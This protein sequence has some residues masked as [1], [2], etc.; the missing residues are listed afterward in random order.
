M[1]NPQIPS[2]TEEA[3]D[4]LM[5]VLEQRGFLTTVDRP[6]L[7]KA[8]AAICYLFPGLNPD[9]YEPS[10]PGKVEGRETD[11]TNEVE[12][13]VGLRES[14]LISPVYAQSGWPTVLAPIVSFVQRH[15]ND[16]ELYNV[17][18]QRAGMATDDDDD[19]IPDANTEH[20]AQRPF[21]IKELLLEIATELRQLHGHVSHSSVKFKGEKCPG[22]CPSLTYAAQ[23][24]KLVQCIEGSTEARIAV[25]N[26][27]SIMFP[28]PPSQEAVQLAA[29]FAELLEK[30][31]G[32]EN[33]CLVALRN[34]NEDADPASC[35]SH[36]FCDAN[37]VMQKACE[38]TG[39]SDEFWSEAWDLAKQ[40]EFDV[41]DIKKHLEQKS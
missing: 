12:V 4:W 6:A 38:L 24:E 28:E 22:G 25:K 7:V 3:L 40:E 36:D 30:E 33:M 5:P 13:K 16:S 17:A 11:Y 27:E 19:S 39:I 31:I 8:W 9:S 26:I 37:E 10:D 18:A 21:T 41:E 34:A 1:N 2:S 29:M 23:L 35:A 15:L 32:H 14:R 20:C